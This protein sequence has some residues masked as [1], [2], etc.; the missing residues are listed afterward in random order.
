MSFLRIPCSSLLPLG[1]L[2]AGDQI[3]IALSPPND[4]EAITGH[5]HLCGP[6]PGII[7]R[8][9]GKTIRPGGENRQKLSAFHAWKL[10]PLREEV[11]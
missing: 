1:E 9:H 6:G 5:Q 2:F 4:R 3:L 11:P 8:R 10:A 7:V